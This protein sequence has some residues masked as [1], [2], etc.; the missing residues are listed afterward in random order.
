MKRPV[1]L[2]IA[3]SLSVGCFRGNGSR[4]PTAALVPTGE[5]VVLFA[6]APASPYDSIFV[7]LHEVSL[8]PVGGGP[9]V[10]LFRSEAGE[11]I[12]LL[13]S[14]NDD[15]VLT[16]ASQI[17]AGSYGF[18]RLEVSDVY[19]EG[20]PCDD[21]TILIANGI[22][23]IAPS[24][25]IVVTEG[26]AVS[27]RIAI[28]AGRSLELQTGS[29]P[30]FCTFNPVVTVNAVGGI[31]LDRDLRSVTGT[32][33]QI[34]RSGST[35]T[36]LVL[37][38]GP[39]RGNL[40]VVLLSGFSAFD[41]EGLPVSPSVLDVGQVVTARGQLDD[42]GRFEAYAVLLGE[43]LEVD[44]LIESLVDPEVF[45]LSPNTGSA[46]VGEVDVR[47]FPDTVLLEQDQPVPLSAI[48]PD[49]MASVLGKLVVEA[50]T[51]LRAAVV[52]LGP[53]AIVGQLT[54]VTQPP[55]GTQLTVIPN[56]SSTPIDLI[57]RP[58]EPIHLEG[59]GPIEIPLLQSS[60]VVGPR[61][62]EIIRDL[63]D[64]NLAVAVTV[65]AAV[66]EGFV[67]AIDLPNRLITMNGV[68]VRVRS[69]AVI[70]DLISGQ[71]VVAF[72]DIGVGDR[73]RLFGLPLPPS[74]GVAF[75]AFMVLVEDIPPVIHDEGCC[76][77][78]WRYHLD[79]WPAPYQPNTLFSSVFGNAFPGKTLR[80][81]LCRKGG[82]LDS[83]G[84]HTVA[85]LLNAA[86]PAVAFPLTEAQVI[87]AFN[88]AV[89]GP[90]TPGNDDDD[91]DDDDGHGHRH[92]TKASTITQL[93]ND[94]AALN[95]ASCPLT[96][97][98]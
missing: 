29:T 51:E 21:L 1:L 17:P 38:L 35:P 31:P 4:A 87:Q 83:L 12:D 47:V 57:L 24:A 85:A 52:D 77:G 79:V 66:M 69:N 97:S 78:F 5:V 9:P 14:R 30:H 72:E 86:S 96:D 43:A 68:F 11:Q 10:I 28:D 73:V 42:D 63:H 48:M 81:V 36:E 94:F 32:I 55:G 26:N 13:A 34:V 98:D 39:D 67:D 27:I 19:T 50:P 90:P 91:D 54:A 45:V 20:G 62:V 75:E 95:Q 61:G 16:I 33:T 18:V 40:D 93:K 37:D 3:L 76:P 23:D 22:V 65:T 56:G 58:G 80:Q 84:R 59:D 88:D 92:K 44:G 7:T 25:P 89:F 70:L 41:D 82:G 71:T 74:T 53:V 46:V 6:D 8:L 2:L 64:P 15:L 60:L 49:R